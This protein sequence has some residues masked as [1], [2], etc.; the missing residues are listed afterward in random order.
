MKTCT[1]VAVL[2]LNFGWL[3]SGQASRLKSA[4]LPIQPEMEPRPSKGMSGCS[5]GGKFYAPED[6]WHPDLGEPFGQRNHRGK[7]FG[8]V[9]CKNIKHDCPEPP[10]SNPVLLPGHCCRSCPKGKPH[11]TQQRNHR[12]KVSCKNIKHDCPEPPCSNPVL[13]PGHCCR[14]CPKAHSHAPD[15]KAD[16]IFDGFEYF[17]EKDDDLH[18]T[19]NDRSYLSSEDISQ[20]DSRTDFVALLTAAADSRTTTSS[21][22][23]K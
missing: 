15:K 4:A 1:L 13:L 5:F 7:V 11:R 18:K 12:G 8:K 20:D 3:G 14:S 22:V 2:L 21:G 9:S 10:C 16:H 6:T 23:A 19:Y 17:Q